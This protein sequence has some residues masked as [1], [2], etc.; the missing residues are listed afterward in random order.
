MSDCEPLV[1]EPAQGAI[2][3][4]GEQLLSFVEQCLVDEYGEYLND[5]D[6]SLSAGDRQREREVLS[7]DPEL[8]RAWALAHARSIL[9]AQHRR[10]FETKLPNAGRGGPPAW[11]RARVMREVAAGRNVVHGG[12]MI[13]RENCFCSTFR[14]RV[15]S[16]MHLAVATRGEL[17]PR[18]VENL[19]WPE[20]GSELDAARAAFLLE[21]ESGPEVAEQFYR[22]V[23]GVDALFERNKSPAMLSTWRVTFDLGLVDEA[24]FL[25]RVESGKKRKLHEALL[26]APLLA[27]AS[28]DRN[29]AF[30]TLARH[31]GVPMRGHPIERLEEFVELADF[32]TRGAFLPARAPGEA[33]GPNEAKDAKLMGRRIRKRRKSV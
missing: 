18:N 2:G 16:A 29:A 14:S 9:R 33:R 21:Q 11:L 6:K 26:S 27:R 1:E 3:P 8:Q 4:V 15:R 28:G 22:E 17:K 24:A 5:H 32:V 20:S 25:D 13:V 19:H 12:R 7:R 10:V 30:A 31:L 23:Y